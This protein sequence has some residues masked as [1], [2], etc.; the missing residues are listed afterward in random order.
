MSRNSK[1]KSEKNAFNE[2]IKGLYVVKKDSEP[3][4]VSI[5]T[6]KTKT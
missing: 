1:K 4:D 2:L 3:K 6:L 5:E